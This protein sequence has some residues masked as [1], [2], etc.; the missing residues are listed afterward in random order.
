MRILEFFEECVELNE[1]WILRK[2]EV[3]CRKENVK[4][5]YASQ[6]TKAIIASIPKL[7]L[8][9]R[10]EKGSGTKLGPSKMS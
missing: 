8:D 7:G 2:I 5:T 10:A 1:I 6:R 3:T 4:V 9:S